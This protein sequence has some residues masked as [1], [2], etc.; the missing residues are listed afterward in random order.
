[1][2]LKVPYL[3]SLT[4]A[5]TG[6]EIRSA[7][8]TISLQPL[9]MVNWKEYYYVPKVG[10][11]IA[12][13]DESILLYY[14]VSEKHIRAAYLHSNEPVYRDSCVEFFIS[15]DGSNYYN[16]E[17]NCIGTMLLAYGN[18][19]VDQ[20]KLASPDEISNIY[21]DTNICSA[22]DGVTWNL[23]ANIPFKI[24]KE[25]D[26]QSLKG[27]ECSANFYKCGDDLPIPHFLSWTAIN[28]P[29]PNFHLPAFFG[30]LRFL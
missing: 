6:S 13:T 21:R 7:L 18:E 8:S 15:F 9:A 20:R 17:F 12:Y 4:S 2:G 16:F 23:T 25:D 14:E 27:K 10:F 19:Q 22:P 1:M 5:S 26:V 3:P 24:F 28:H 29:K 30:T 11:K